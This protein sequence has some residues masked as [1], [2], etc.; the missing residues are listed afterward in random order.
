M[1]DM[2]KTQIANMR[3]EGIGYTRISKELGISENTIKSYCRR[4]NLIKIEDILVVELPTESEKKLCKFCGKVVSQNDKRKEKLFCS[5]KCRMAWWNS[6]RELVSHKNAVT[7]ECPHCH[8][9]FTVYGSSNRKYCC[10]ACYIADR[11]GGD[12]NE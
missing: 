12:D 6:H 11:F 1:N 7:L 2:Q 4:N 10:H 3:A 5:D 8:R 9:A